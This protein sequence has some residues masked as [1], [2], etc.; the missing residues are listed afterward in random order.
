MS[1]PFARSMR[2]LDAHSFRP[3]LLG[4]LLV[5]ALLGAWL[6]WLFLARITLYEVSA[7][8]SLIG[9]STAVADF[10]P[11]ALG[12]LR[13]GQPARL[14]LDSFP[15]TQYGTVPATVAGVAPEIRDGRL[16]VEL[17]LQPLATSRI[18]LQPGLTG[19]AEV[20]VERVSP[21]VLVLR[22]AGQRIAAPEPAGAQGSAR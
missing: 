6:S 21:A 18:P 15:W 10:P 12:R 1:I 11:A 2:S 5:A 8:A 16:Q 9:E 20:E 4:L 22:A 13:P 14:R 3:T 17:T 19:S 7:R